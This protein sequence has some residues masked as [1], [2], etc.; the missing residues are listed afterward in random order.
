MYH[1]TSHLCRIGCADSD[2]LNVLFNLGTYLINLIPTYTRIQITHKPAEPASI[3]RPNS[4]P[5]L[6][7]PVDHAGGM[8]RVQSR[9]A[10]AAGDPAHHAVP[11]PAPAP[12]R[13][14]LLP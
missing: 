14:P 12:A 11:R 7:F 9:A 6:L 1:C 10:A 4:Q 3:F 5:P 8:C 2:I 13:R